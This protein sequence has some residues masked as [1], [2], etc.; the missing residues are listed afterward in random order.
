MNP[1]DR[2]RYPGTALRTAS[3]Y[4]WRMLVVGTVVYFTVQLL[5][6]L[7]E[8][9]IPFIVAILVTAL[10]HPL[11]SR[12]R[13]LGLPRGPSTVLTILSAVLVFGGLITVVVVRA[14]EQAPQLGAEI[15]K[16]LPQV[17]HWLINGP[18]KLNPTTVNNIN[19]TISEDITKNSSV[20]ASTALSTGKTVATFLGGLLLAIFSVIFLV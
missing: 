7:S 20:I 4:G 16:L 12:L 2:P 6:R 17:K 11:A 1:T 5:T 9:V 13:R 10:L 3:D 19:K 8:V 15:N 14:A 18:L